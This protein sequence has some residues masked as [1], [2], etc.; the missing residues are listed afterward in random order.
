[1]LFLI[2]QDHAP[3]ECPW[4]SGGADALHP[5]PKGFPS[6]C[7]W[8]RA[9]APDLRPGDPQIVEVSRMTSPALTLGQTARPGRFPL[10][11]ALL[12]TLAIGFPGVVH[13]ASK[14]PLAFNVATNPGAEAG[15]GGTGEIVPIPLWK[16][17]STMTAVKYGTPGFPSTA[18]ATASNGGANLFYC[19]ANTAGSVA[20]QRI[21]IKGRNALVDRGGLSLKLAV[22]I[23][24]TTTDGDAGRMI[25]R[26]RDG[27][28]AVIGTLQTSAVEATGGLMVRTLTSGAVPAGTRAL[29][30]ILK[31]TGTAGTSCDVFFDNVSVK[32]LRVVS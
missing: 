31:G 21:G 28:G 4:E 17:T 12:A 6:P 23:G 14:T 5:D 32:L 7:A 26:Y 18:E 19:G 15:Q 25:V 10:L 8:R 27:A 20:R 13:A 29:A 3:V 24:S 1:M 9:P 2:R 16:T 11:V 30:V 22:R